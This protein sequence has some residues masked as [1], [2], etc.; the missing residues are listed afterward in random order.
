MIDRQTLEKLKAETTIAQSQLTGIAR[1]LT[2]PD[3]EK[4]DPATDAG[5]EAFLKWKRINRAREAQGLPK[6]TQQE[7]EAQQAVK[8]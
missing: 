8:P 1:P 4:A 2:T 7:F 3:A 6:L 5:L